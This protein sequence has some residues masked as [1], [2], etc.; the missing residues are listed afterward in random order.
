MLRALDDAS[1]LDR[2]IEIKAQ[3]SALQEELEE[4]KGPILFALMEE[5]EE[6]G[7][8]RGFDLL[9]QRRKTYEY[10]PVVKDIEQALKDAKE[11]E[12]KT[13]IAEIVKH[14]AILVLKAHKD[15]G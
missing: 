6:K 5:P 12:R 7:L 1:M 3:I 15:K 13:G 11:N 9:I 4:L 14:Q 2:Y 8:Y 10:S